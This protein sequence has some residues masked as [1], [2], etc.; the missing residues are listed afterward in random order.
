MFLVFESPKCY[1]PT[2]NHEYIIRLIHNHETDC[3]VSVS[4]LYYSSLFSAFSFC[5]Q[6]AAQDFM[7]FY[8]FLFYHTPQQIFKFTVIFIVL[9]VLAAMP[10]QISKF[11]KI[12]G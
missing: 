8:P 12:L 6:Q 3:N 7:P 11:E 10:Q 4:I 9:F 2:K 1:L 5:I